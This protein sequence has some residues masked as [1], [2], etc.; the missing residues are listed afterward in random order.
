MDIPVPPDVIQFGHLDIAFDSRVRRPDPI[1]EAHA[2][3]A[4][5]L[6]DN[7]PGGPVLGVHAGVGHLGLLTVAGTGRDL[8]LTEFDEV[9]REY[10]RFNA[11]AAGM[12]RVQVY[13]AIEPDSAVL[14]RYALVICGAAAE[15]CGV[16]PAACD[17][18]GIAEKRLVP[19]GSLVLGLED[20]DQ[21][22]ELVDW[23]ALRDRDLAVQE[24]LRPEGEGVLVVLRATG[25]RLRDDKDPRPADVVCSSA[26]RG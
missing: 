23:L 4:R 21:V 20:L 6:L 3:W 11:A 19:G 14:D 1:S 12:D 7:G 15:L 2:R 9:A 24:F 17:C 8:V 13:P 26:D 10:A 25:R 16:L 22:V 5:V 18:I